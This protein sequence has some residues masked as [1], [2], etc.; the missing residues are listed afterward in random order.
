MTAGP[1]RQAGRKT[2][3]TA[4]DVWYFMRALDSP[5]EPGVRPDPQA[6]LTLTA[7]PGTKFI[8][9]KL[10]TYVPLVILRDR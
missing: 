10:C 4:S 8:G 1:T 5:N 2:A 6:E 7:N 9:C 3:A